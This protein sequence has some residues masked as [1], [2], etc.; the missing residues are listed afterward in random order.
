MAVKTKPVDP[1]TLRQKA[2]ELLE[3]AEQ[4]ER[5]IFERVGRLTMKYHASGFEGFDLARFRKE[6]EGALS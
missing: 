6:I 5:E 2:K 4:I 1:A 3:Q